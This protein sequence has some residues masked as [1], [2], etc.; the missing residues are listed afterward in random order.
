MV[1]PALTGHDDDSSRAHMTTPISLHDWD[2]PTKA[3]PCHCCNRVNDKTMKRCKTCGR[4]AAYLPSMHLPL[5]GMIPK[6]LRR[7]QAIFLLDQQRF[8]V[9]ATDSE[10][11]TPAH[12]ACTYGNIDL[13]E[14]L[15][16]RG[17]RLEAQTKRGWKP[18][19]FAAQGGHLACVELL[20]GKKA[21]VTTVTKDCLSTPLHVAADAGFVDICRRLLEEAVDPEARD[22]VR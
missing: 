4:S 8:E 10:N 22:V 18:L 6:V 3:W 17:A 14:V 12:L 19:H 21:R 13:L 9:N 11:W 5:F 15:V 7:E 1:G 2:G 16:D 20:L